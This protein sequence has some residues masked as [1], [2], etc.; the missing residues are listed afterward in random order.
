MLLADKQLFLNV[1]LKIPKLRSEHGR[2]FIRREIR[3][4]NLS[5]DEIEEYLNGCDTACKLAEHYQVPFESVLDVL[6]RCENFEEA[7][8]QLILKKI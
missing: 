7:E 3:D 6:E 2:N 5:E 8:N 1:E 4:G